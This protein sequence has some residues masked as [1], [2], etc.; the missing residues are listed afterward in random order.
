M[1]TGFDIIMENKPSCRKNFEMNI[2]WRASL[3]T[4]RVYAERQKSE[5]RFIIETV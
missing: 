4:F 5:K 1:L 2:Q 3:I